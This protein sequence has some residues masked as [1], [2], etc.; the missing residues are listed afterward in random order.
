MYFSFLPM[1]AHAPSCPILAFMLQVFLESSKNW[2]N[3]E[4]AF[5]A[6]RYSLVSSLFSYLPQHL[7][8]EYS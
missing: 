7:F 3:P 6:V 8:L 1:H 2:N 4:Y 5:L